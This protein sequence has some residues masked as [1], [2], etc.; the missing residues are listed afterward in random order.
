MAQAKSPTARKPAAPKGK[1]APVAPAAA[2]VAL[3]G[4]PA[5]AAVTLTG[6]PYK[7]AAK[8][9]VAWWAIVAGQAT[10]KPAPVA[11]LLAA[12]VPSHFIAYT[13]RKGCLAPA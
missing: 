8:H 12:G 7:C 10:G 4:G 13:M 5:V 2:Y 3:R 9:N 1:Q 11:A 6:T